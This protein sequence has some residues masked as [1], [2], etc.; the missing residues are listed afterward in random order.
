[1][2]KY[3]GLISAIADE[4]H[5]SKGKSEREEGETPWEK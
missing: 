1:M 5:I 2:K 3:C 4:F